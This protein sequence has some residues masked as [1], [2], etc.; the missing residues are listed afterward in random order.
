MEYIYLK[1][2]FEMFTLYFAVMLLDFKTARTYGSRLIELELA[3]NLKKT[4]HDSAMCV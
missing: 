4:L 1:L 3:G 2:S